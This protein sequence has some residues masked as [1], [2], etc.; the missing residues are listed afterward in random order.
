M[1]HFNTT[2]L[3]SV[4]RQW[5]HTY[6]DVFT[7]IVFDKQRLPIELLKRKIQIVHFM[8]EKKLL[9]TRLEKFPPENRIQFIGYPEHIDGINLPH[10]HLLVRFPEYVKNETPNGRISDYRRL[11]EGFWGDKFV[12]PSHKVLVELESGVIR[13]VS[14]RYCDVQKIE[15]QR[16]VDYCT[17]SLKN[18]PTH[19]DHII[20]NE[21]PFR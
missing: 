15:S 3:V 12:K 4:H 17:K 11:L 13:F 7:T 8:V 9:G 10:Y 20:F 18:H 1:E 19:E 16:V 6:F 14:N 2:D 21:Y 5:K